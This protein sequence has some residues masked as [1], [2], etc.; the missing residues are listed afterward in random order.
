MKPVVPLY[1]H[2]L[3]D[4]AAWRSAAACGPPLNVVVNVHNG[5]GSAPD[6]SYAEATRAL[7]EAGVGML[8]YVYLSYGTRP[9]ADVLDDVARWSAYPV[10]GAFLDCAPADAYAAGQI[11]LVVRACRRAGMRTVLL[12]PGMPA[13][14]VYH[15]M[16]DGVGTFEGPWTRY[17]NWM[18][19]PDWPGA[20]HLVYGVPPDDVDDA[21]LL[22]RV[23]GAGWGCVTDLDLPLPWQGM[24][25]R[26]DGLV[27]AH[28]T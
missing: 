19:G 12:N 14:P 20:C 17:R 6:P 11:R 1:I 5:P 13:D 4:P 2:P 27:K 22:V 10:T 9:L 23:R 21:L 3:A 25:R 18:P 26:L 28:P 16:A 24:P 15:G 7:A 8:G